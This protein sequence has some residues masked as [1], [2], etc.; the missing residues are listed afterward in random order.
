MIC[1][2]FGTFV[3]ILMLCASDGG[4]LFEVV[5]IIR[6]PGATTEQVQTENTIVTVF[7]IIS[8]WLSNIIVS[9][10]ASLQ[11]PSCWMVT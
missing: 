11:I 1:V 2:L 10:V 3:A 7:Q 4:G 9:L 5:K 6:S 8:S